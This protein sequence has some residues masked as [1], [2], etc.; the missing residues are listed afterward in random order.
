MKW[1]PEQEQVLRDMSKFVKDPSRLIFRLWG[2]AGT[3]KTTLAAVIRDKFESMAWIALAYTGKAASR[4][5]QK[6]WNN[7]GTMHSHMYIPSS[8][9]KARLKEWE[10]RRVE[11]ELRLADKELLPCTPEERAV[12]NQEDEELAIKIKAESQA[13]ADPVFVMNQETDL[14]DYE[15]IV[16]DEVSMVGTKEGRDLENLCREHGIKLILMGDPYQLP[17]VKQK[18]W[19]MNEK[20]D[21]ELTQVMR[22]QEND[23]ILHLAELARTRQRIPLG[24]YGSSKVIARIPTDTPDNEYHPDQLAEMVECDQLLVGT[25][26]TRHFCNFHMRKAR[27]Y[28][29]LLHVG[30]KLICLANSKQNF[31]NGSMWYVQEIHEWDTDRD[32]V[33]V[34]LSSDESTEEDRIAKIHCKSLRGGIMHFTELSGAEAMVSAQAVTVHKFQGSEGRHIVVLDESWTARDDAHRWL[35]TA[36]TRAQERVTLMVR[37]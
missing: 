4:L 10:A 28:T 17:P 7:A 31:F 6:G 32:R 3:G 15:V 11:I 20:P 36:L 5:R 13:L 12:L 35:Y 25:N 23:P 2:K 37:G 14:P 29:D 19:F 30:E 9:S 27:G 21:F 18:A 33:V 26:D 1:N 22:Q 34:T 24:S 8:K 16:L